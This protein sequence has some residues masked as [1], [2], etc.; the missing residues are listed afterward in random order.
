MKALNSLGKKKS[1][2]TDEF[3]INESKKFAFLKDNFNILGDG[4]S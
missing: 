3:G 2:T 1:I 4:I